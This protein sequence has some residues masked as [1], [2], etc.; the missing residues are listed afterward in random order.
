M[1]G[2]KLSNTNIIKKIRNIYDG[3]TFTLLRLVFFE[4]KIIP[5]CKEIITIEAKRKK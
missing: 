2:V 5:F 3:S 1:N 4:I